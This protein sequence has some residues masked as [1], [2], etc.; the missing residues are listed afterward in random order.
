MSSASALSGAMHALADNAL[1]A[2]LM[3][4]RRLQI[5]AS[6]VESFD[7]NS[8]ETIIIWAVLLLLHLLVIAAFCCCE[9]P[10]ADPQRAMELNMKS[11]PA[12]SRNSARDDDRSARDDEQDDDDEYDDDNQT[13]YSSMPST[14]GGPSTGRSAATTN[15][16]SYSLGDAVEDEMTS[17]RSYRL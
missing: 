17:D 11:A 5:D 8:I 7:P 2:K 4:G 16:T 13:R 12:S 9:R 14:R 1:V 15:R 10:M 3:P 6:D